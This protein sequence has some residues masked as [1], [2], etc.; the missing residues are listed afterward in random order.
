MLLYNVTVSVDQRVE[1]EWL[2]WMKNEHI[3]EVMA[4]GMFTMHRICRLVQP[5]PQPEEGVTYAIQYY[6]DSQEQLNRYF[7]DFAPALQQAHMVKYGQHTAA[8]RTVLEI[9]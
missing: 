6:C 2:R 7:R 3:P 8:F 4:T 9:V 1:T 5:E